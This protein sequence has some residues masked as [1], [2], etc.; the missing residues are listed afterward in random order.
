MIDPKIR[1]LLEQLPATAHGQALKEYLKDEIRYY[2]DINK[3]ASLEQLLGAQKA[4]KIMKDVFYFLE[5]TEPT[6]PKE[7]NQYT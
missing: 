7:K 4:V 3:M 1:E 5:T 2:T 6:K